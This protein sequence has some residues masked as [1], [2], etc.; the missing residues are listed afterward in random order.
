[1]AKGRGLLH[2]G[3][4]QSACWIRLELDTRLDLLQMLFVGPSALGPT[5]SILIYALDTVLF[6]LTS[7]AQNIGAITI[8]S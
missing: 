5:N 6:V 4:M 3:S 1:M 8:R 7:R 2:R